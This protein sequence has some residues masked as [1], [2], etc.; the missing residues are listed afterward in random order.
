MLNI[1]ILLIYFTLFRYFLDYETI[2]QFNF[3]YN[4]L[5]NLITLKY[6]FSYRYMYT[7]ILSVYKHKWKKLAV[8]KYADSFL[9]I[10]SHGYEIFISDLDMDI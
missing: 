6:M 1:H 7:L 10:R 2:A 5:I 8:I 3:G 9:V 4:Y